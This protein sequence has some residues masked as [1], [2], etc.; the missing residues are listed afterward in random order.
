M[1]VKYNLDTFLYK[2]RQWKY[3]SDYNSCILHIII[4]TCLY[5]CA[6]LIAYDDAFNP[7]IVPPLLQLLLAMVK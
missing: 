4:I 6:L 7:V 2:V 5:L 1:P 3:Y